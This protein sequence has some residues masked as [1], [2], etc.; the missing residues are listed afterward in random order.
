MPIDKSVQQVDVTALG[1][2]EPV[3]LDQATPVR[4]VIERMRERHTGVALLTGDGDPPRL[5]GIFTE[6]DVLFRIIGA[7]NVLDRPVSELMTPD[8]HVMAEHDPVERAVR[9]MNA[10]DVR[11]VPVQSSD[12]RFT[13]CVRHKDIVRYLVEHCAANVL[14]LP[15][16][17]DQV[18][19]T[20]NGG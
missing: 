6:R 19:A 9:I 3:L 18:A 2:S 10:E 5:V 7:E 17:P 8:P 13:G 16:D 11:H 15:P 1:L 4:R 14:N 20:R 12:G